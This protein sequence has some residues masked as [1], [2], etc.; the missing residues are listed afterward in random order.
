MTRGTAYSCMGLVARRRTSV[1]KSRFPV[2]QV[3]EA[4]PSVQ[5]V[6]HLLFTRKTDA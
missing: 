3:S 1:V 6:R 4:Q 5:T 2:G